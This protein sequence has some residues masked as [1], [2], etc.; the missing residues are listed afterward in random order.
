MAIHIVATGSSGGVLTSAAVPLTPAM[1]TGIVIGY[2]RIGSRTSRVL[3]L[4]SIA[5]KSV[6]TAAY[7]VVPSRS[8]NVMSSGRPN[9][10]ALKRN[11]T[12]GTSRT[13]VANMSAMIPSSLP[14]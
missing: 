5:A 7:P 11:A 10:A 8:S 4:T 6:P 14:R 12:I 3:A 9:S 13:S 2:R 1:I